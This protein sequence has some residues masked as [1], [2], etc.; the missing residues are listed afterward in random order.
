MSARR[1]SQT[2]MRSLLRRKHL[3]IISIITLIVLFYVA[4]LQTH[5][6]SRIN[7]IPAP[8]ASIQFQQHK[9]QEVLTL[10]KTDIE[11]VG[12]T[13]AQPIITELPLKTKVKNILKCLD[14]PLRMEKLQYGQYWLIKNYIRGRRS[15]EMG[16]GES[17]TYTTNGDYTFM[18]NLPTVVKRWSG[19]VSFAIYAPGDD[20]DAT[21]DSILYVLNCLPESELIRD[22]ATF[23]IYFPKDHLPTFIAKDEDEA[24]QWPYD[25]EL[26]A[27]Y[28]NVNHST[29]Y[30]TIKNLTYPINVGRNI[31]R[32]TA[33]TYFILAC[34]IELYPSLGLVDKFLEMVVNNSTAVLEGDKPKVFVLPIFEVQKNA[35][36]PDN[37]E[38]LKEM[39]KTS[40][41]VPFHKFVCS[42]CH[43]VP[44]QKEWVKANDSE[45][46][47][48][49]SVGK[50]YDKFIYWEPFYISDNKEPI[51]DER[52]TWEGQ[53][54]KRIQ[55][56]AMCLIDYEYH[57]LHPAFLVHAPG[58]KRFK[59]KS[60]QT[61]TRMKYKMSVRQMRK[62]SNIISFITLIALF[63]IILMLSYQKSKNNYTTASINPQHQSPDKTD[64][65]VTYQATNKTTNIEL[66]LKIKLKNILNCLD[67]PL[68]MEMLEYGEYWLIKNYIR[69][70]RSME[71]GCGESIT[72]TTHGD[73]TFMQHLPRVLKRWSGPV[74]FALYAPGYDYTATMDSILHVLN[75]LPESEMIND[76]VTFHIYFPKN[77]LPSFIAKNEDEIFEWAYDCGPQAPYLN[78]NRSK[79][80]RAKK[81]LTYPINV[82]RNIA[83]KA[84]NTYYIFA[85][86]IELY[87]S[88]GLVD[89]FL[90]MVGNNQTAFVV[91]D[92]RKVFVLPV[93]EVQKNATLPDNKIELKRMLNT[94]MAV[95]FHKY[96]CLN[97]HLI[98]K[99]KEWLE[100]NYSETLE[101]FTVGKRYDKFKYWEPF[102][103]S[104]NNEPIFDERVTWEGKSDK[105]I[106]NYAM[107]LMD[108]EYHVLHPAFLV[109]APGIK[110]PKAKSNET[111]RSI[112]YIK[113]MNGIIHF[114]IIPEYEVLYGQNKECHV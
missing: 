30:K 114:T 44:N 77:H 80:Y 111:E 71:M 20:Y 58:I 49:F 112:K 67:A 89:K 78:V 108:Y 42:N 53:S 18:E 33:N 41:A 31:A 87:P 101:V 6:S 50:R 100:A 62:H 2:Q 103:I 25:C 94:T 34:D 43:L 16:C 47:E 28:L 26:P 93:F 96:I 74:S 46:L 27:P 86:D 13:S 35:T 36:L 45:I 15:I 113:E 109:H 3:E 52:V 84:A 1:I 88:L 40:M 70:Q 51:F 76:Y 32:K 24:L 38:E 98:P 79:I 11:V 29:M 63:C 65:K 64:I 95:P 73:Y 57:V 4:F 83:R 12:P 22:Y 56:Y 23:H 61:Q 19:P 90:E 39:L 69:G 37:K 54:N 8:A 105:R 68:R 91:E 10:D 85:C 9:S 21:M 14:I 60:N 55:N 107:C 48:I 102:Y 106:Q 66:P 75:C 17:I 59:L 99:H 104:D 82:G 72:Y 5:Q 81:N 97:C 7:Y 92:K 110:M